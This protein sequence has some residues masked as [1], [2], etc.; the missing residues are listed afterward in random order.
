M[1][2]ITVYLLHSN[3]ISIN[4]RVVHILRKINYWKFYTHF[5]SLLS[6]VMKAQPPPP[7]PDIKI[8]PYH[9]PTFNLFELNLLI[10]DMMLELKK[11]AV[12]IFI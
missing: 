8:L 4:L 5:F 3:I 6:F 2:I 9:G 11:Y 10:I 7:P 12:A 1:I